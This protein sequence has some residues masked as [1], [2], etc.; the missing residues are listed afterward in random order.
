MYWPIWSLRGIVPSLN[1]IP[2]A[3]HEFWK[4]PRWCLE[5]VY[6]GCSTQEVRSGDTRSCCQKSIW[7]RK[8][9]VL[10]QDEILEKFANWL[11]KWVPKREFC[12]RYFFCSLLVT[13]CCFGWPMLRG[14]MDC[15]IFPVTFRLHWQHLLAI[16]PIKWLWRRRQTELVWK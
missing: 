8:C 16:S 6:L 10:H 4:G 5:G 15:T 13:S 11:E 12:Y 14:A 7:R 2:F 1:R 3:F 9:H